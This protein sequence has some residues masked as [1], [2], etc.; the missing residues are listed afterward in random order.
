MSTELLQA[1]GGVGGV[2]SA[3]GAI[4]S[5][6]S[7]IFAGKAAMNEALFASN[8]AKRLTGELQ[9]RNLI[10]N[11]TRFREFQ[12]LRGKQITVTAG[13]GKGIS[14]SSLIQ[15]ADSAKKLA[16][17][18]EMSNR[19]TNWKITN[20][21]KNAMFAGQRAKNELIAGA[22]NT[23][24]TGLKTTADIIK[25]QPGKDKG[26]ITALGQ[27]SSPDVSGTEDTIL[28]ATGGGTGVDFAFGT[29]TVTTRKSIF[30][31]AK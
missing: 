27:T 31:G 21:N 30:G 19:E 12:D 11:D 7:T 26:P 24:A 6:F 2:T 8:E 1:S 4:T 5:I 16:R 18:N 25:A 10:D 15:L 3:A 20:I 22:I 28:G 17:A 13:Q 29:P 9:E 14:S 23:A